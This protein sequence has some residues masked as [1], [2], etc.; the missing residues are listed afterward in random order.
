MFAARALV[1]NEYEFYMRKSDA[2]SHAI[3]LLGGNEALG[4]ERFFQHRPGRARKGKARAAYR[5]FALI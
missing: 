3:N 1:I 5:H 4:A 2:P